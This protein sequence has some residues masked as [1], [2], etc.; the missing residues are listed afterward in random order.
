[1]KEVF[2]S[3]FINWAFFILMV[4]VGVITNYFW[5][6]CIEAGCRPGLVGDFLRPLFYSSISL[7]GFFGYFIFLPT[8]YFTA[9]LKKVF[10]WAFPISLL[11]LL[12]E[13]YSTGGMFPI[14]ER[15]VIILL[16][17]FFGA[18]T[19][20]FTLVHYLKTKK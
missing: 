10:S 9:W 6:Q 7:A 19:L 11:I 5:K 2:S 15:E 3:K 18:V 1:M 17:I 13:I 12:Q 20:L 8:H 4:V 14:Y 16:S